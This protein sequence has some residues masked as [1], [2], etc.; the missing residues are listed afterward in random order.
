[1]YMY[2]YIFKEAKTQDHCQYF[3]VYLNQIQ[4]YTYLIGILLLLLF[5]FASFHIHLI[6]LLGISCSCYNK[7]SLFCCLFFFL[8]SH[9]LFVLFILLF[10]F[11]FRKI[12]TIKLI[13]SPNR[14]AYIHIFFYLYIYMLYSIFILFSEN[15]SNAKSISNLTKSTIIKIHFQNNKF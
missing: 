14:V 11:I 15:N 2:I 13:L 5:F 6:K 3:F 12:T 10:L 9:C 1:M 8:P 4:F 7:F